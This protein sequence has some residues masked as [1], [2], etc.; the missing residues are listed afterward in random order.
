M[1]TVVNPK[2]QSKAA[3]P[4]QRLTSLARGR[5]VPSFLGRMRDEFDRMFERFFSAWPAAWGKS[6]EGWRWG[7]DVLDKENEVV[8]RA[9]APGFEPEDFDVQV[10]GG[11]L[12]LR[13]SK[14]TETK[15]EGGEEWCQRECYESVALPA[16]IEKD[17][18]EAN[19]RNGVL[20]VTLPKAAECK[21]HRV[22]VKGV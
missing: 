5:E 11:Q 8:V 12:V 7:L 13:A 20:T 19:Y 10:Q 15:K 22:T 3:Q 2:E 16:S 4:A 14:K 1:I 18:V 17:K 6:S 21:G 9:E